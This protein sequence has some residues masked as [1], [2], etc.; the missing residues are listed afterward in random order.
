MLFKRC[1]I[2]FLPPW[3]R[4]TRLRSIRWS[5]PFSKR[6]TLS[7]RF[8]RSKI[9]R[10]AKKNAKNTWN[11]TR[12]GQI[13]TRRPAFWKIWKKS[14]QAV[15]IWPQGMIKLVTKSW[16]VKS[17]R[18]VPLIIGLMHNRV[19]KIQ[20]LGVKSGRSVQLVGQRVQFWPLRVG[21]VSGTVC[22][23][24]TPSVQKI[25]D[26]SVLNIQV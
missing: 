17:G 26:P 8:W 20:F 25:L 7:E 11:P 15:P 10:S 12:C 9:E 2:K 18:A 16:G 1:W 5:Y 13:G 24:L 14:G 23:V 21:F 19:Y 4:G 3:T 22:P 6:S